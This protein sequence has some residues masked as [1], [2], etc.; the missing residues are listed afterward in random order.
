[1]ERPQRPAAVAAPTVETCDADRIGSSELVGAVLFNESS[2]DL[3]S[4]AR[5]SLNAI[6]SALSH[7]HPVKV[8]LV[9]YTDEAGSV[10]ANERLV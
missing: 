1:M 7:R 9:G 6:G 3:T 8:L 2:S 4:A 5:A 10:T